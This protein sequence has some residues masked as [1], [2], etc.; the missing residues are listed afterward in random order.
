M[1]NARVGMKVVCINDAYPKIECTPNLPKKDSIYVI[2]SI[3]D[4]PTSEAALR[5]LLFGESIIGFLLRE[6]TNPVCACIGQERAFHSASFRP[7]IEDESKTDISAL[8][9]LLK[10]APTKVDAKTPEKV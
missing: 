10:T 5:Y 9:D 8:V 7:V 6:I 1:W 2:R 3:V 4:D